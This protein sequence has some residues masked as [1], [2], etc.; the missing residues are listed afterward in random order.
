MDMALSC[1]KKPISI[2]K[3]DND[4][5]PQWFLL[6]EFFFIDS[7]FR[8]KKK[9]ES[10]KKVC[11]SKAFCNVIMP[12]E[13]TKILELNQYQKFNKALSLFMQILNN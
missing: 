6:S 1:S 3:R 12:S 10:H 7:F 2:I 8:K 4:K 9:P 13:D 5:P 11:E